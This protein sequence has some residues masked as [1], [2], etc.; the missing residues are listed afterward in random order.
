MPFVNYKRIEELENFRIMKAFKFCNKIYI[1]ID[2]LTQ[3][4]FIFLEFT[5][6]GGYEGEGDID[7]D[8]KGVD[9]KD[10]DY[11]ALNLLRHCGNIS[12]E[13][14]EK[15]YEENLK[16]EKEEKELRDKEYEKKEYSRLKE[17][18]ENGI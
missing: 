10:N 2:H 11:D 1:L 8:I 15:R 6:S 16:R 14:A 3:K 4:K 7:Y 9:L 12:T 13:E 5:G 18:F 17:K